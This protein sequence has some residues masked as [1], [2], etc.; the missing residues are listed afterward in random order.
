MPDYEAF[1]IK[2]CAGKTAE[3][4]PDLIQLCAD[5]VKSKKENH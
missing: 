2:D 5:K 1:I 3:H 4:G